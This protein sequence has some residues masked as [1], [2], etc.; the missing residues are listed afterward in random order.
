[1]QEIS[2]VIP[3]SLNKTPTTVRTEINNTDSLIEYAFSEINKI[4]LQLKT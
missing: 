3:V 1:M 2:T 4:K